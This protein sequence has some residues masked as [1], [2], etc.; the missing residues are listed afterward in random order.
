MT[1]IKCNENTIGQIQIADEVIAII[2]GTAAL[3][4]EGVLVMGSQNMTTNDFVEM[5]GKKNLAKGVKITVEGCEVSAEL[6]IGVRFGCNLQEVS[7][8]VQMKVKNAVETMTG[9]TVTQ[10]NVN[11]TGVQ[12]EKEV[13]QKD[14]A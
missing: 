14:N 3:E 7:K 1:E 6:S 11:V 2:A 4:A 8:T 10:V 12:A 13:K 5:L 9:L